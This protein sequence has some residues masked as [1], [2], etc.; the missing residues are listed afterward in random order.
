MRLVVLSTA[1]FLAASGSGFAQSNPSQGGPPNTSGASDL[2]NQVKSD[3]Q[4]AGFSD[5]QVVPQSFLVRAKDK[6]GQPVMMLISGDTIMAVS[7]YPKEG[8]GT[9][10]SGA[11][12]EPDSDSMPA[13]TNGKGEDS[14]SK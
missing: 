4:Q 13:E 2:P 14:S 5:V 10:G 9:T 6:D 1:I 3:L 11:S 7:G 12:S 8:A